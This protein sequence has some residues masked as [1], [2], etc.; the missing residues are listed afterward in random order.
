MN[1]FNVGDKVK[2]TGDFAHGLE[3]EIVKI[4]PGT[5]EPRHKVAIEY[6]AG[7]HYAQIKT[8]WFGVDEIEKIETSETPE[9][10]TDEFLDEF[11]ISGS[12]YIAGPM[13]SKENYNK[14][15]FDKAAT[16]LSERE[17]VNV[18]LNPHDFQFNQDDKKG[19]HSHEWYMREDIPMLLEC[20]TLA[21]IDDW[22][23]SRG[24]VTEAFVAF[25][26]GIDV[27]ELDLETGTLLK[28]TM[29]NMPVSMIANDLVYGQRRYEYNHPLDNF[30]AIADRWNLTIGKKL[31][32][33]IT[34]Q[35]VA[36]MMIDLKIA[37]QIETPKAD[38]LTDIV[39]YTEA[40]WV[41]NR[42][43]KHRDDD[44]DE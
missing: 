18:I 3:G 8:F 10:V 21:L 15:A 19:E 36:L 4:A 7:E 14:E 26:A 40:L 22:W 17:D 12:W 35:D 16:H 24:A 38:N 11:R 34:M 43:Q 31:S 6:Y 23:N 27:F 33:E 25:R 39:G 5:A 29:E 44:V 9:E 32:A 20:D 28:L 37:R 2:V 42:E 41:A 13:A 1:D 30:S